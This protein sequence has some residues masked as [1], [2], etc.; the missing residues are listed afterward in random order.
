MANFRIPNALGQIR[1][2]NDGVL[3]GELSE[4]FN[5]DLTSSR[6]KIKNSDRLDVVLDYDALGGSAANICDLIISDGFYFILTE[7]EVFRCSIN[8]DPTDP[9]NWDETTSISDLDTNSTAV[10]FDGQMRISLDTDI[11]AWDGSSSDNDWW[12]A[13]VGGDALQTGYPHVLE[14]VQSQKETLY[15]TDKEKVHYVEKGGTPKTVTLDSNVVSCCLAPGLSGAMW[16]GSYNENGKSYVYEIYTG[17]VVGSTSVYRQAYPIDAPAVLAI[18]MFNN[19]PHIVTSRGDIQ[20]FNGAGFVTIA[21]FPFRFKNRDI[22]G[23][24]PGR[25]EADNHK[26]AVHPRGVKVHNDSVYININTKSE[27]NA[28]ALDARSHSG[29]WEFDMTT[30]KLHHRFSFAHTATSN[31]T[32]AQVYA[33]PI[34][35]INNEYTFLMAGG[36]ELPNELPGGGL[37]MTSDNSSNQS[38]F[39]TPELFSSSV[40]DAQEALYHKAK[41]L[42]DG[43]EIVTMYRN[44][45]RDTVYG[46]V[47]WLSN[48]EF[49]TTDDWSAVKVGELVRI[50]HGSN[51]GEYA[52]IESIT[53]STN[54]TTIKLDRAIGTQGEVSYA[55]SDNF[56][57]DSTTYTSEN[58]EYQKLGGYG[59]NPWVQFAVFMKGNIEYRQF[60]SK[61]TVKNEL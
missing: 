6:G 33:Y 21:S 20:R 4:T 53:N 29:V 25:I 27:E 50:S 5:V 51:A 10:L 52:N 24:N 19:T 43:E 1:Q 11:L 47:N 18:W 59:V 37:Y 44:T 31:G 46:T 48:T 12:T 15:V 60:I 54:T 57:K 32:S 56:L 13:V 61:G 14:K 55:Y 3:F 8:N 41:T 9:S 38:W 26:R 22:N 28:Y 23:I 39:V 35:V 45:T 36:H 7:D 49:T 34:M 58:G 40:T 2:F 16:V 17:E 42:S 30:E